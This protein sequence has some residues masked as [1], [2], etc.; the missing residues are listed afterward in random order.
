MGAGFSR[1]GWQAAGAG[2]QAAYGRLRAPPP[3]PSAPPSDPPPP[4][5]VHSPLAN[6]VSTSL[7]FLACIGIL[8]PSTA[9][10][11][12]GKHVMT[13]EW[14]R[15]GP[16][17]QG[18]VACRLR[19]RTRTRLT[20]P[21]CKPS[22]LHRRASAAQPEPR[23]R[24]HAGRHVRE[25]GRG[26]GGR[27]KEGAVGDAGV[28]PGLAGRG[29]SAVRSCVP[30]VGAAPLPERACLPL[31]APCMRA[32][33]RRPT[34]AD[35][36]LRALPHQPADPPTH[37]PMLARAA[38]CATCSSSLALTWTCS[39]CMPAVGL[40][41]CLPACTPAG[42]PNRL[43]ACLPARTTACTPACSPSPPL[44]P[45]HAARQHDRR[46]RRGGGGACSEPGGSHCC[47]HSHHP[48]RHRLLR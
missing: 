34:L 47:P 2:C 33:G 15:G 37:L 8:I 27:G 1:V 20:H 43:P 38:T 4:L 24:H 39:R 16:R 44:C 42:L 29:G 14:G 32:P 40:N 18:C 23:H 36:Q 21:T 11:I 6:K 9:R 13:G 30:C 7:L 45:P 48:H 31:L 22:H 12:Y 10:M 19:T 28:W 3:A 41:P 26:G 35:V 5:L 25:G 17:W 46:R